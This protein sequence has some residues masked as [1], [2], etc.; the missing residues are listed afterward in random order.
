MKLY[1]LPVVLYEPSEDTEDK[2]MAEVPL[3]PGCRAWGDT[4]AE[5]LENLQSVASAFIESYHK[6]GDPLPPEVESTVVAAGDKVPGEV[7]VAG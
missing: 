2:Y 1:K 4:L 6:M 7:L 3:L 5:V